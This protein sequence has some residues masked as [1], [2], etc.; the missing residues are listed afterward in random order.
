MA[1]NSY[2]AIEAKISEGCDAIHN[3]WYL[4]YVQAASAYEVPL[5]QL[6]R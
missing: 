2:S 1:F 3:S 4:N 6:Q 5:Y